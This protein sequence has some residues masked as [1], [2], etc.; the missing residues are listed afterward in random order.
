MDNLTNITINNYF[1]PEL[2]EC[3]KLRIIGVYCCLLFI[4][5]TISNSLLL[6]AFVRYK[7]LRTPLNIFIIALVFFNLFGTIVELPFIVVSNLSCKYD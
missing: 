5:S 7:E 6:W 2:V 3:Y 4:A 1:E